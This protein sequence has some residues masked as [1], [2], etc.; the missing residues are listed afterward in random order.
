MKE[1]TV[2]FNAQ[3]TYI[4]NFEDEEVALIEKDIDGFK[5]A[6]AEEFRESVDAD[7]IQLLSNQVFIRDVDAEVQE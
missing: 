6:L 4:E 2:V 7:D 3:L 5:G 1:I